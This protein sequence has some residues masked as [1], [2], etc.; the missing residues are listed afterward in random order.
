[1]QA[2]RT[3]R[4]EAQ[5]G[6][7]TGLDTDALRHVLYDPNGKALATICRAMGV[8]RK[9]FVELYLLVLR[10]RADSGMT[11]AREISAVVRHYDRLTPSAASEAIA[12]CRGNDRHGVAEQADS[13]AG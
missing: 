5:I 1:L 6:K 13:T 11:L 8:P 9:Q 3:D 7:L 4:F 10:S 12:D 2:G